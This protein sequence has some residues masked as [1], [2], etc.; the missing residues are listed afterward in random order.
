M[1]ALITPTTANA[2]NH[3]RSPT[4]GSPPPASMPKAP[5]NSE[6]CPKA[7][8]GGQAGQ[9]EHKDGH[10]GGGP[11]MIAPQAGQIVDGVDLPIASPSQANRAN[12]PS[13][14]TA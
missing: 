11:R 7:R 1:A 9:A 14:A 3:G 12:A 5:R 2:R 8:E 4:L 6:S 10:Y 13:V